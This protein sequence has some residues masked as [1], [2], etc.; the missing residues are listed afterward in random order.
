MCVPS[1]FS[2]AMRSCLTCYDDCG[3]WRLTGFPVGSLREVRASCWV[4]HYPREVGGTPATS[5]R[6]LRPAPLAQPNVAA[7]GLHAI[8]G[9]TG[10]KAG[11]PLSL[12]LARVLLM[13]GCDVL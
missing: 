8:A 6:V 11:A 7:G 2:I 5:L 12:G 3:V 13:N 10:V 9:L 1:A 4:Y